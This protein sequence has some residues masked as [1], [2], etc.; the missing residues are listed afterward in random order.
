MKIYLTVLVFA[1]IAVVFSEGRP[2]RDT[3]VGERYGEREEAMVQDYAQEEQNEMK[4]AFEQDERVVGMN[5]MEEEE[6]EENGE[7]NKA[8]VESHMTDE[9]DLANVEEFDPAVPKKDSH[10]QTDDDDDDNKKGEEESK[11]DEEVAATSEK[12][13]DNSSVEEPDESGWEEAQT[14]QVAQQVRRKLRSS[15][16]RRTNLDRLISTLTSLSHVEKNAYRALKKICQSV[17]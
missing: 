12:Q 3:D 8:E 14:Q 17:N 4:R 5:G 15:K 1:A 6:E 16:R 7:E 11:R 2:S 9:N 13:L 10:S